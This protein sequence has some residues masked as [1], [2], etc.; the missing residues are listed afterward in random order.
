MSSRRN[1]PFSLIALRMVPL[2]TPL[3]TMP[4]FFLLTCWRLLPT[5]L[6]D[7]LKASNVPTPRSTDLSATATACRDPVFAAAHQPGAAATAGAT[8]WCAPRPSSPLPRRRRGARRTR[9]PA[10]TH[11]TRVAWESRPDSVAFY[12]SDQLLTEDYYVFS[13][14]AKALIRTNNIDTSSRLGMSS[15]V[16]GYKQTL[17]ADAP[18][19]SYED[20]GLADCLLIAGA[21][22]A[23]AHPILFSAH[24]A[25]RG[26]ARSQSPAAHDRRRAT[27]QRHRRH[28]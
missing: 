5:K 23:I 27:P 24:P 13:K 10:G 28:R 18:P 20:I 3:P 6:D 4:S 25:H 26:R 9:A 21:N 1:T 19:C 15:A 12:V 16:A 22:P 7:S 8:E 17:A 2:L 14:L 11:G